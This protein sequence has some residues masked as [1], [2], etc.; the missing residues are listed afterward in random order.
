MTGRRGA[1][2]PHIG[3]PGVGRSFT[4]PT[5]WSPEQAMAVFEILDELRER[6]W[7]HYGPQIQQVV[8]EE[9]CIAAKPPLSNIDD[10]D[11]PF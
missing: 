6:V 7:A 11:V 9:Q 1:P 3:H 4:L 10:A 8:R 2:A 5:N